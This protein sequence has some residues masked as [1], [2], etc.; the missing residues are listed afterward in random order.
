MTAVNPG[1]DILTG[2]REG[3]Q[4]PGLQGQGHEKME[5]ETGVLCLQA[6]ERQGL[7]GPEPRRKLGWT[8]QENLGWEPGPAST[9]ISSF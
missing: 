1:T 4:G 5:A 3:A 6:R 2:N 9:S 8:D 7:P